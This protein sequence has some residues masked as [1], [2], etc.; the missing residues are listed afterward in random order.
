MKIPP[1]RKKP[2]PIG[3]TAVV[4]ACLVVVMVLFAARAAVAAYVVPTSS[5]EPTVLVGDHVLVGRLADTDAS[6]I[7][8]WLSPYTKISRG[9]VVLFRFPPQPAIVYIKRVIGLPGD[10]IRIENKVVVLNGHKLDEPYTQHI[11][12]NFVPYR[13][14]FPSTPVNVEPYTELVDDMLSKHVD[15]DHREV[16]VPPGSCF[17][18]GDN[19]DN[20]LDSRYWGFL[21]RGNVVGK[22][23]TVAFS[24]ESAGGD[25]SFYGD[26]ASHFSAKFRWERSWKPIPAVEIK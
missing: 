10:H 5:M 2:F 6:S 4:V 13:D 18:L 23:F 17:V 12:P 9:D 22:P 3:R 8:N 7:S 14:S 26:M 19:R 16:I 1:P 21:P 25:F 15:P 11:F 24:H 20:S